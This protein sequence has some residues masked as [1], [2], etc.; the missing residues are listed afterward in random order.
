VL[1]PPAPCSN[2]IK[3][4]ASLEGLNHALTKAD[5]WEALDHSPNVTC[6]A[7]NNKAFKDAGD[8]Q[9]ALNSTDLANALLYVS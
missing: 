5:L 1:S 7:P 9:T 2:T 6:L 8:P 4:Q 3:S